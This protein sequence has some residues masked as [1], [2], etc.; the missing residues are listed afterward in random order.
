[1]GKRKHAGPT[2]AAFLLFV[3]LFVAE[4]RHVR[5]SRLGRRPLRAQA[6]ATEL[7]FERHAWDE[8]FDL[9]ERRVVSDFV[10]ADAVA[11]TGFPGA[12]L[13]FFTG[14][15]RAF[16]FREI[17]V[18]VERLRV[19]ADDARG[20][21]A[22]IGASELDERRPL[23]RGGSRVYEQYRANGIGAVKTLMAE[24]VRGFHDQHKAQP[25]YI[26]AREFAVI[27]VPSENGLFAGQTRFRIRETRTGVD[28]ARTRFQIDALHLR[29][30]RE[31]TRGQQNG[32]SQC[33]RAEHE[34]LSCEKDPRLVGPSTSG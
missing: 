30:G 11:L 33:Q 23:F 16:E 13:H 15:N 3:A 18:D 4:R 17:E 24:R 22:A 8:L 6:S 1:G 28:L 27:D 10:R 31:G 9:R 12:Q 29:C 26:N 25:G 20:T 19:H 14:F 2:F 7:A 21:F 5:A 32:S 34:K